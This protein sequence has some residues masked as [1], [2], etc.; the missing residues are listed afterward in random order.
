[1]K[2][3]HLYRFVILGLLTGSR[4]GVLVA[5]Q[6]SWID[7]EHGTMRRRAPGRAEDSRKK[8]PRARLGKALIRLLRLWKRRDEADGIKWVIHY[9]GRPVKRLK[10]VWGYAKK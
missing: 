9:N 4:S 2:W 10:R 5:L 3:P 6:W 7:L 1:M 8:T